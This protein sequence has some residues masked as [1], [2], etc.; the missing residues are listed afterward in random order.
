[1]KKVPLRRQSKTRHYTYSTLNYLLW[2]L[3]AK[4]FLLHALTALPAGLLVLDLLLSV[5]K[6]YTITILLGQKLRLHLQQA[7]RLGATENFAQVGSYQR[8]GVP[9][10][11]DRH[12]L[13]LLLVKSTLIII[14]KPRN[15]WPV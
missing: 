1:M 6:D 10:V 15:S 11:G 9:S 8:L 13:G 14:K 7:M 2:V 3:L 5:L 12:R 4:T